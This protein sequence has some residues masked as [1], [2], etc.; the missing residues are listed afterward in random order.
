MHQGKPGIELLRDSNQALR[1]CRQDFDDRLV[2]ADPDG[3]LEKH[4]PQTAQ[5]AHPRFPVG[6]H[7]LLRQLLFILGKPLLELL[8]AGLERHEL[9]GG[10]KLPQR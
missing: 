9:S 4:R 8:E 6:L 1:L 5:G 3:K 2:Q 10:A 7:R